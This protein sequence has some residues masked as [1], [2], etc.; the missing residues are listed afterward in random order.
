MSQQSYLTTDLCDAYADEIGIAQPLF[1]DY[2]GI[3]RFHG[4]IVT[5]K[6]F[7]DNVLVKETLGQK[8]DGDVLVVDGGGSHRCALLGDMLAGMAKDNGW[9][10]I[11]INGCIRDSVEIAKIDVGVKALNTFPLKSVKRGEGQKQLAVHFAGVS[12]NPGEY[13]YAD[14]DGVIIS[15]QKLIL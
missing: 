15:P 10:G 4:R 1:N 12:F 5:V 3:T 6:V 9:S 8:V 14:E 11:I 2:G 7:E 13:V